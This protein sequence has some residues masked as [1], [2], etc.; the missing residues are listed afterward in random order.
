MNHSLCFLSG[1]GLGAGLMCL[2]DAS[3]RD[4]PASVAA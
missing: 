1:F 4:D 2:M 3:M